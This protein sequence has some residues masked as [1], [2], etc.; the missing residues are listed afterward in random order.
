MPVGMI[1]SGLRKKLT[2]TIAIEYHPTE[3]DLCAENPCQNGGKCVNGGKNY[4]CECPSGYAG[5]NCDRG[6]YTYT[7]TQKI[8]CLVY[9]LFKGGW[10]EGCELEVMTNQPLI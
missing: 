9:F 3:K 7:V 6:M 10:V 4:I 2:S 1:I 5:K 8:V